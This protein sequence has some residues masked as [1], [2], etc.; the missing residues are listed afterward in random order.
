MSE[1]VPANGLADDI[2]LRRTP[3]GWVWVDTGEAGPDERVVEPVEVVEY[4]VVPREVR[5]VEHLLIAEL[6]GDGDGAVPSPNRTL[7]SSHWY[8]LDE[9]R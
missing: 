2:E 7:C 6:D 8:D 9:M 4:A 3:D 1:R 5:G